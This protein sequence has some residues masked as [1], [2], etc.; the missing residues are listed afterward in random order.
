MMGPPGVVAREVAIKHRL[1]SLNSFRS[2]APSLNQ[3]MLVKQGAVGS[4]IPPR[5]APIKLDTWF[6]SMGA[7]TVMQGCMAGCTRRS[8]SSALWR[9]RRCMPIMVS[10]RPPGLDIGAPQGLT[11]C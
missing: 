11:G 4:D 3:E 1:H 6:A 7:E 5:V 10:T 8:C 2:V 9:Q